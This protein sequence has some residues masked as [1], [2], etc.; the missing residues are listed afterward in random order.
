[1]V[2]IQRGTDGY[3]FASIPK[4]IAVGK[5]WK[6]GDELAF[7]IVGGEVIPQGGDIILR[8]VG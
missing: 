3:P 4:Q 1:M 7:M 5:G 6:P 8:K 2:R